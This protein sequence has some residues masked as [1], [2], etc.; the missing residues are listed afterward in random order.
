[1]TW[2][3]TTAEVD[4][5]L[6]VSLDAAG[7]TEDDIAEMG[8]TTG[9]RDVIRDELRA[10]GPMIAARALREAAPFLIM[11]ARQIVEECSGY[12]PQDAVTFLYA[13]AAE[14]EATS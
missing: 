11:D 2:E 13:R 4:A 5:A 14:L 8:E 7:M 12:S 9:T 6:R 10:A 3:P 1:M